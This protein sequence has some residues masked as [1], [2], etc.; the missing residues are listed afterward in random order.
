MIGEI[1]CDCWTD[2]GSF[3]TLEGAIEDKS[4]WS[5]FSTIASGTAYDLIIWIV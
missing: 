4:C 2:A 1:F 5:S 3:E